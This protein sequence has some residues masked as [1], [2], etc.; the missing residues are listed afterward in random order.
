[1]ARDRKAR[2]SDALDA[3]IGGADAAEQTTEQE[4]AQEIVQD[5]ARV[6]AQ[7]VA[8]GKAPASAQAEPPADIPAPKEKWVRFHFWGPARLKEWTRRQAEALGVPEAEVLRHALEW[9]TAK[10]PLAE[11][12]GGDA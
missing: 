12:G 11:G 2:M 1:M 5:V 7:G 4:P 9:Y 8:Q 10:G 3:L 6:P